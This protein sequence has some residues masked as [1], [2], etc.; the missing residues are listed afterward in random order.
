LL[1]GALLLHL[2]H[3]IEILP[4]D[5]HEAG[6]NDGE[7]GIATIGHRSKSRHSIRLAA[8]ASVFFYAFSLREPVFTSF[9]DALA[10]LDACRS[11]RCSAERRS[12]SMV[13]KS[14]F[15]AARR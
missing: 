10:C 4:A 6:Q 3:V 2:R 8:G 9:E 13:A 7:D 14:R 15:S 1:R 5:Q 11:R 12:S